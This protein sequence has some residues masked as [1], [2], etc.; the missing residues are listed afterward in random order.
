VST[1][2]AKPI[3]QCTYINLENGG[4]IFLRSFSF[5][6]QN[7]R[8]FYVT[9][10]ITSREASSATQEFGHQI[11]ICSRTEKNEGYLDQFIQ[12]QDLPDAN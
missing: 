8:A 10:G 6:L 4:R 3:P 9:I 7:G 12:S 5:S 1:F 11:S 2:L